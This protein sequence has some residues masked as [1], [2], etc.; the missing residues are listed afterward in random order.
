MA[1]VPLQ[2]VAETR[3]TLQ[4]HVPGKNDQA[5]TPFE[6]W[7]SERLDESPYHTIGEVASECASPTEAT[8][9]HAGLQ[10]DTMSNQA[11]AG[12]WGLEEKQGEGQA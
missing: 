3:S 4:R 10:L 9:K 6:R 12:S 2:R 5:S 1:Y 7:M 11:T 8:G